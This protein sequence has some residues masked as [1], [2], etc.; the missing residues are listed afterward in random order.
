MDGPRTITCPKPQELDALF[1][2]STTTG[3]WIFSWSTAVPATFLPP[4]QPLRNGLYRNNRDGTFTDVTAKAGVAN[5]GYGMGVAVGDYNRDG[6]P[7]L[8]VTSYNRSH[9]LPQQWRWHI[10]RRYP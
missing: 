2:I 10:Y 9:P 6:Y 5:T 3:G 4:P 7:D 1:S 8:F